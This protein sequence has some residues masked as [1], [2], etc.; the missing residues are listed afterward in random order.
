[1]SEQQ[2]VPDSLN[3]SPDPVTPSEVEVQVPSSASPGPTSTLSQGSDTPSPT[4]GGSLPSSSG[5]AAADVVMSPSG[6]G[7]PR[8]H[9]RI[10][11]INLEEPPTVLDWEEVSQSVTILLTYILS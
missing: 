3:I 4:S 8:L 6:S 2:Q 10:S 1:M 5:P 9:R 7:G 11:Q